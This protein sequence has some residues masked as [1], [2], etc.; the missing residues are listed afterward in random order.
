MDR[1]VCT[2]CP[3]WVV[4]CAHYEDRM[5]VLCDEGTLAAGHM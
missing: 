4:R 2:V 3:D 1:R 5:V